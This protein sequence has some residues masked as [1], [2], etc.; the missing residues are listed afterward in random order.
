MLDKARVKRH[1]AHV[2]IGFAAGFISVLILTGL[3]MWVFGILTFLGV[4]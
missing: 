2:G 1:L 3:V 4:G